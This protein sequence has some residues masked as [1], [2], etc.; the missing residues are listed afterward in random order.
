MVRRRHLTVG[1]AR[2]Q[3]GHGPAGLR[4]CPPARAELPDH[5]RRQRHRGGG[6]ARAGPD[7]QPAPAVAAHHLSAPRPALRHP[8]SPRRVSASSRL[9]RSAIPS[10]WP[11]PATDEHRGEGDVAGTQRPHNA[12][13]A[14]MDAGPGASAGHAVRGVRPGSPAPPSVRRER[15]GRRQPWAAGTSTVSS[16]WRWGCRPPRRQRP[17]FT[18]SRRTSTTSGATASTRSSSSTRR[19]CCTRT[20]STTCTSCSTTTGTVVH[21]CRSSS[22]ACRTSSIA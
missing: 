5:E 8:R 3:P 13:P 6:G 15:H 1:L 22:S 11:G 12:Q 4:R 2:R 20:R 18:P 7:P 17:S 16:A 9:A 19:T 14:R 10:F 21:S